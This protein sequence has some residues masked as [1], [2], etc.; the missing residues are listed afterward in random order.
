MSEDV[1]QQQLAEFEQ[2]IRNL[3]A[4][5]LEAQT[6]DMLKVANQMVEALALYRESARDVRNM[7]TQLRADLLSSVQEDDRNSTLNLN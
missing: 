7:L 3:V 2:K 1:T 5:A 4:D 6:Q